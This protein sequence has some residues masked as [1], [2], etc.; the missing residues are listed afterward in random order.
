M[1]PMRLLIALLLCLSAATAW[2]QQ[3][4]YDKYAARDSLAV[5]YVKG[6]RLDS[7]NAMD[8]ILIQVKDSVTWRSLLVEFFAEKSI[9]T[10]NVTW[11]D[12]GFIDALASSKDPTQRIQPGMKDLCLVCADEE[13][14]N[15]FI[16]FL[17]DMDQQINIIFRHNLLKLKQRA[18]ERPQD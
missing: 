10:F 7:A 15:V 13:K 1:K 5:A 9:Q 11:N 8:V 18:Q 3:E 2:S 6:F 16:F 4:I 14:H 17:T 12:E